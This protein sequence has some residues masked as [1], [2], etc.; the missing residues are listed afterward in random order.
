MFKGSVIFCIILQLLTFCLNATLHNTKQNRFQ[1]IP[2]E[3]ISMVKAPRIANEPFVVGPLVCDN[4]DLRNL[5]KQLLSQC[6]NNST[7]V[8]SS[9]CACPPIPITASI[10]ITEP[11]FYCLAQDITG[12]IIINA[13]NVIINMNNHTINGNGAIAI[14]IQPGTHRIIFNGNIT[15]ADIG[16][17]ITNSADTNVTMLSLST[18]NIGIFGHSVIDCVL[19]D[20]VIEAGTTGI[21]FDGTNDTIIV[22]SFIINGTSSNGF[23]SALGSCSNLFLINGSCELT[24]DIA[25]L[26]GDVSNVKMSAISVNSI[27]NGAGGIS[28]SGITNGSVLIN[29]TVAGAGQSGISFANLTNGVFQECHIFSGISSISSVG[30][31][32]GAGN[33]NQFINCSANNIVSGIEL[34]PNAPALRSAGFHVANGDSIQFTGCVANHIFSGNE[35]AYGFEL[36]A[37]SDASLRNC[38]AQRISGQGDAGFNSTGFALLGTT[39]VRLDNCQI[40]D[41]SFET[42]GFIID[43]SSSAVVMDNCLANQCARQGYL[44][45]GLQN[46]FSDCQAIACLDGFVIT[47][48]DNVFNYCQS[49]F[50]NG[51][52]FIATGTNII[53][54][55][56]SAIRNGTN[57]FSG[58]QLYHCFATKNGTDYNAVQGPLN[59]VTDV[60]FQ[61]GA[62]L[63]F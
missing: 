51:S 27:G 61:A 10:T 44:I 32:I 45:E 24:G 11:G 55:N 60:N 57:G 52:G 8:T 16:I 14:S 63:F 49:N 13:D 54:G 25:I 17:E 5:L 34:P 9:G 40:I 4:S 3:N 35:N 38:T 29:V 46:S 33:S 22:D 56:C 62:N 48:T 12:S 42:V 28:C 2:Q 15:E 41:A 1:S 6:T 50:N 31:F 19:K 21:Q 39:S 58:V 36:E 30:F 43:E 53:L 59:N 23:T 37:V 20:M 18:C 26:I 47:G 7:V